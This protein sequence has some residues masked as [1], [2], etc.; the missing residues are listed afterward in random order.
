M[1]KT[2]KPIR[3][4]YRWI[5]VVPS[6]VPL[7]NQRFARL[8]SAAFSVQPAHTKLTKINEM[9]E[10]GDRGGGMGDFSYSNSAEISQHKNIHASP[11]ISPNEF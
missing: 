1:T 2:R 4:G 9:H 10:K 7:A 6:P 5:F 3:L 8:R 11:M